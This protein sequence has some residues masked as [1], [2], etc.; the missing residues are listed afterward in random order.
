METVVFPEK[1]DQ[2]GE[3]R[4]EVVRVYVDVLGKVK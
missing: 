3:R 2:S 1:T 4:Q